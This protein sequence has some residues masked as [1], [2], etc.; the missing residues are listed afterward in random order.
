M[1]VYFICVRVCE[2]IYF[3]SDLV[4]EVLCV[5]S[6]CVRVCEGIYF[7]SNLVCEVLCVLE[8][9]CV[10]VCEGIFHLCEGV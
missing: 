2:G 5:E 3:T 6:H 8:S 4:C 10:R 7:T 9:H 1:R